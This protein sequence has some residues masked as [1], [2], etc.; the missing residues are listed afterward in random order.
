[1]RLTRVNYKNIVKGIF[2]CRPNRFIAHVL[3]GD[4]IELCHVK[5]TGRCKELLTDHAIVYLEHSDNMKRKTAYSLICV[6]KGDRLINMDSQA[7]NKVF[8]EALSSSIIV[9]PDFEE[10]SF[11]KP[12]K[13]Y[14][15]SRFDFYIENNKQAGFIEVKGVTLEENG[16]VKFPDAPTTRG[17]KH[18]HELVNATEDGYLSYLFFVVQMN[19]V[20]HF[21]P[22]DA[23]QKEFGL[24]LQYAQEKGVQILAYECDVTPNSMV[25]NGRHVEV[26]L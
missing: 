4:K 12:E 15:A 14:G 26:K 23:T 7:P 25:I 11:I 1:M 5:N 24:A 10:I 3:I 20:E 18:I 17:L 19:N 9:L 21:T 13:V 22:N 2:I 6:Q 16:V 8:L